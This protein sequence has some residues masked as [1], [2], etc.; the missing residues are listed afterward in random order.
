MEQYVT[1]NLRLFLINISV[2]FFNLLD[3]GFCCICEMPLSLM[4]AWLYSYQAHA[5]HKQAL[6]QDRVRPGDSPRPAGEPAN[7]CH[8]SNGVQPNTYH[9]SMVNTQMHRTPCLTITSLFKTFK[10]FKRPIKFTKNLHIIFLVFV[11]KITN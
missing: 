8:G 3:M 6:E 4:V 11:C 9:N 7:G 2:L 5:T 1:S 10:S